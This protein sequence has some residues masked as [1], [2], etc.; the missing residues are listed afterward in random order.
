[1]HVN[2]LTIRRFASPTG[3]ARALARHVARCL[4]TNPR[5]VLGLPTGRTPIRSTRN[6]LRCSTPE[7]WTSA[8]PRPSTSTN[9]SGSLATDPRSYRAFMQR[10]LFDRINLPPRQI[11]FLNGRHRRPA[12][13]MPPVRAANRSRWRTRSAAA[14]TWRQRSHRLQRAGHVAGRLHAQTRLT[15]ATRRANAALFDHRAAG[16]AAPR[17]VDG[18]GD[19]S[20]RASASCCSRPARRRR[21]R[22]RRLVRGPIT[23]ALPASFLQLHRAVEVWVDEAAGAR[24]SAVRGVAAFSARALDRRSAV[25]SWPSSSSRRR[26]STSSPMASRTKSCARRSRETARGYGR[27]LFCI[28][29]AAFTFQ[30]ARR[31]SLSTCSYSRPGHDGDDA[32]GAVAAVSRI[33]SARRPSGCRRSCRCGS[34]TPWS[35]C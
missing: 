33:P 1:M 24:L 13:R 6:S 34:S 11:H 35:A 20:S 16:R 21:A 4:A 30:C 10:H 9:S 23:P 27:P 2:G 28:T 12:G 3:A 25:R 26:G 5:L 31:S 14:R 18:D 8:A 7:P 19:D 29:I 15:A 32:A 22:C 17:A